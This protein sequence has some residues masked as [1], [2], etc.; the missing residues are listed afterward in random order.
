MILIGTLVGVVCWGNIWAFRVLVCLFCALAAW[1]WSQ[2]LRISGKPGQP[3]LSLTF[4]VVYPVVL[5]FCC[6]GNAVSIASALMPM[7]IILLAI[8]SFTWE[9]RRAIV[10][11]RALRSVG[12]TVL[13]FMFPGWM[14]AFAIPMLSMGDS[15]SAIAGFLPQ[16]IKVVLWVVVFTKLT[17]I[18]AYISGVL[19]GGRFFKDKK[20]IPHI[21]PKKTWEGLIGSYVLSLAVGGWLGSSM[22]VL[23]FGSVSSMI[24]MTVLFL[25][26][27]VGD[28]AG[29]LVKRSL[30]VKDSGSLLPGIGGIF[31]LIDSPAFTVP[32]VFYAEYCL[33]WT[34][35]SS[36][37]VW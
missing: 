31:D 4:G 37:F 11:S 9:M 32:V 21:S 30:A 6:A 1:E 18:C 33:R 27:V 13:S 3:W 20:L 10:G 16:S 8:I 23:V 5:S 35:S 17:D 22:G 24:L 2:M 25:L 14:F 34:S 36:L 28:L 12:N 15:G 26:A 19:M 29:S 7:A